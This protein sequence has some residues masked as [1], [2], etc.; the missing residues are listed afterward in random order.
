MRVE[1]TKRVEQNKRETE[2]VE[3]V[4]RGGTEEGGKWRLNKYY[5]FIMR[6]LIKGIE[7]SAKAAPRIQPKVGSVASN[8]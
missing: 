7:H 1:G 6:K 5:E 2:G 3:A 4:D 8:S